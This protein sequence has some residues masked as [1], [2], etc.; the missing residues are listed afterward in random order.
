MPQPMP[1]AIDI[2]TVELA[3]HKIEF[4]A[5]PALEYPGGAWVIR[6]WRRGTVEVNIEILK[7]RRQSDCNRYDIQKFWR[8]AI[9][10]DEY[11]AVASKVV[12]FGVPDRSVFAPPYISSGISMDGTP[13]DLRLENSE[14][15]VERRSNLA[16]GRSA[17]ILSEIFQ[18]L[19]AKYVPSAELPAV[20][21]RGPH[22][23]D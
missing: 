14:W 22:N 8:S 10:Q 9:T 11:A 21:W 17:Q 7:L 18:E 1:R 4:A 20:D 3:S 16:D 13:I 5:T 6:L 12:T 2:G 15:R 19:A 23:R